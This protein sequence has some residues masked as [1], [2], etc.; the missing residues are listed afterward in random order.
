MKIILKLTTIISLLTISSC[1]T[2]TFVVDPKLKR[3]VSSGNPH[4]SKTSH[5][6]ISG[7]GQSMVL[8]ASELCKESDGVA[9]VESKQS[10]FDGVLATVT[11]GIYTPRTMNIYCNK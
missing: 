4:F 10:F 11:L 9:F 5:F 7:V 6:F 8:N 1:A 3:E 2:Q